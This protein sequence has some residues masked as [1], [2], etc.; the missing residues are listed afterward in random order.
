MFKTKK[1][2]WVFAIPWPTNT[3]EPEVEKRRAVRFALLPGRGMYMGLVSD[4][5]A[6]VGGRRSMVWYAYVWP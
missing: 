6:Q 5:R 4:V 3:K 1:Y 2:D